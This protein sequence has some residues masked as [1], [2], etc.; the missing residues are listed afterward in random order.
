MHMTAIIMV[1]IISKWLERTTDCAFLCNVC[2][3]G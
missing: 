3:K 2:M 1:I